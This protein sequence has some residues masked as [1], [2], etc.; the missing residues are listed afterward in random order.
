MVCWMCSLNKDYSKLYETLFLSS[1]REYQY[2]Y[3]IE[4]DNEF[5]I[6]IDT[7][8]LVVAVEMQFASDVLGLS[9]NKL[10][11]DLDCRVFVNVT[12]DIIKVRVISEHI[13]KCA[14]VKKGSII[15]RKTINNR[16]AKQGKYFI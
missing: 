10:N 6:D 2:D 9:R 13:S 5:V 8:G 3:S 4:V 12:P 7:N 1:K 15:E 16:H 11:G 14:E